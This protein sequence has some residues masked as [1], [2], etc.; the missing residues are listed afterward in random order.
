MLQAQGMP[1]DTMPPRRGGQGWLP[2]GG[3][4]LLDLGELVSSLVLF[5]DVTDFMN[6]E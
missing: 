3:G 5:S 1:E 4:T 6:S 2:L